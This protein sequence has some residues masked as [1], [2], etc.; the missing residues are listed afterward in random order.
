M[1]PNTSE[2]QPSVSTD[3]LLVKYSDLILKSKYA[4]LKIIINPDKF[5]GENLGIATELTNILNTINDT[6]KINPSLIDEYSE[7]FR[8]LI[9]NDL[10]KLDV[11]KLKFLLT[12]FKEYYD[13]IVTGNNNSTELT[14]PNN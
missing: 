3:Q 8:E 2:N 10:T 6:V 1:L 11:T 7:F 12:I 14:S 13:I 5:E 9:K 4:N